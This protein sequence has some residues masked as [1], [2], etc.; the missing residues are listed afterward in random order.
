MVG[1]KRAKKAWNAFKRTADN[2]REF[3]AH[4]PLSRGAVPDQL[5]YEVNPVYL[6][7]GQGG[8]SYMRGFGSIMFLFGFVLGWWIVFSAIFVFHMYGL[9]VFSLFGAL[10][11]TVVTYSW[12]GKAFFMPIDIFT[13]YDRKRQK[14]WIWNRSGPVEVD[15]NNLVPVVRNVASSAYFPNRMSRAM[16]VEYGPD[17]RPRKTRGTPHVI[18]VGPATGTEDVALSVMEYVRRYMEQSLQSL[19][20]VR[21]PLRVRPP[22]WWMFNFAGLLEPWLDHFRGKGTPGGLPWLATFGYVL[23]F[24]LI[25]PM[26]ITNYLALRLAPIQKWPEDLLEMHRRDLVEL[27]GRKTS[28]CLS[29]Q[30]ASTTHDRRKPVIRINGKIIDDGAPDDEWSSPS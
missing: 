2:T 12:V 25:F 8:N 20:P 13:R 17:G 21:H 26:Q 10:L 24:P 27:A 23:F 29:R 15:W 9:A 19:P 7:T 4:R 22:W 11:M 28:G 5:V 16:Y 3:P 18:Q 30:P 14:V 6:Q 1:L